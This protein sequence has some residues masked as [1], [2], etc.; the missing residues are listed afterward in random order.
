MLFSRWKLYK[1]YLHL[2]IAHFPPWIELRRVKKAEVFSVHHKPNWYEETRSTRGESCW[3]T[4]ADHHQRNIINHQNSR[5][6]VYEGRW[7]CKMMMITLINKLVFFLVRSLADV[8]YFYMITQ[9]KKF[10]YIAYSS[11]MA[12]QVVVAAAR[13]WRLPNAL[14]SFSSA[15]VLTV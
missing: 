15:F 8:Y 14:I 10:L 13:D 1:R 9:G 3:C 6:T 5:R 4:G 11:Y 7:S 2:L 12:D